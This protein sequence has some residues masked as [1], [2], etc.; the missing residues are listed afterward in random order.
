MK[1]VTGSIATAAE[2]DLITVSAGTYIDVHRIRLQA[3]TAN[4]SV[5]VLKE[6][7]SAKETVVFN[8][9]G[10]GINDTEEWVLPQGVSLRIQ[11]STADTIYYTVNYD[12][13]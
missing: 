13:R 3:G 7:S 4:S 12:V 1:R 8:G 6:D 2:T 5:A 11:N 10:T 9:I